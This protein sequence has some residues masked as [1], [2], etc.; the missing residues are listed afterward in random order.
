VRVRTATGAVLAARAFTPPPPKHAPQGGIS[1]EF[2]VAHAR[3]AE[4]AALPATYVERLQAEA[5]LVQKV[6]KAQADRL[7]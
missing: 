4:R 1:V 3:A 7:R 2:L 6:Q 5:H